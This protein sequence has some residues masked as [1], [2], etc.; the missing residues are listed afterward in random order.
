MS[1]F[2]ESLKL[3]NRPSTC[4]KEGGQSP[5]EVLMKMAIAAPKEK[6]TEETLNS[7]T[8]PYISR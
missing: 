4:M 3:T 7:D 6:K 2:Y 1:S 5:R 8:A